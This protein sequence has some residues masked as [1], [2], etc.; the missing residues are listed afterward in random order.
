[1]I[2]H[3]MKDKSVDFSELHL[4]YWAYT[5]GTPSIAGDTRDSVYYYGGGSYGDSINGMGGNSFIAA[6]TLMQRRGVASEDDYPYSW[7]ED[8]EMI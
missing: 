7:S 4:S 2:T 5:Q 3:G 1:M 8:P 6:Q